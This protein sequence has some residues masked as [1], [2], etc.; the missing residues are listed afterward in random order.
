MLR[1]ITLIGGNHGVV[2]KEH[3]RRAIHRWLLWAALTG[4]LFAHVAFLRFTLSPAL[5]AAAVLGI[6]ILV[7]VKHFGVVASVMAR[8]R[9]AKK[10]NEGDG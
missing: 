4:L 10:D 1:L 7:V 8:I 5:P 3:S 2:A 9:L 6:V